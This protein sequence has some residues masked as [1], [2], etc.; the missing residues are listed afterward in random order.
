MFHVVLSIQSII[1]VDIVEKFGHA[2]RRGRCA[3]RSHEVLYGPKTIPDWRSGPGG[4]RPGPRRSADGVTHWLSEDSDPARRE[5]AEAA[6]ATF[7][8]QGPDGALGRVSLRAAVAGSGQRRRRRLW[9]HRRCAAN[10]RASRP[11]PHSIRSGDSDARLWAG[12]RRTRAIADKDARRPQGQE[13]RRREGL[14]RA[15]SFGLGAGERR[16]A[17]ERHRARLSRAGRRC[18]RFRARVS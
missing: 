4:R 5:G 14:Q 18:F 3:E 15:Q 17:V 8:A 16:R 6:G 2:K 12:D 7:R 10:L 13:G 1:F 11:R 9:L